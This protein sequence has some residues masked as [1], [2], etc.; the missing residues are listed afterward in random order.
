METTVPQDR[1][2]A[3]RRALRLLAAVCLIG[4]APAPLHAAD[5]GPTAAVLPVA[6]RVAHP[7]P[8]ELGRMMAAALAV[9]LSGNGMQQ[10]T[11]LDDV[12]AGL[13][14]EEQRAR[15]GC[16]GPQCV[17]ELGGALGVDLVVVGEVL[18]VGTDVMWTA[19]VVEVSSSAVKARGTV[20]ANA[21]D[22]LPAAADEMALQLGAEA[23]GPAAERLGLTDGAE[24]FAAYRAAN[25]SSTTAE[26]LTAFILE[27]NTESTGLAVFEGVL[28][29][30]SNALLGGACS[31]TI[32]GVMAF[33]QGQ[34]APA[35]VAGALVLSALVVGSALGVA[36]VVAA[37]VD[38]LT[39]RRVTVESRG[40]CR[41]DAA[42][43][44]ADNGANV[45]QAAVVIALASA[46]LAVGALVS[47]GALVT[48]SSLM[49]GDF[50][51]AGQEAVRRPALWLV[52][53]ALVCS[54]PVFCTSLSAN[55]LTALLLTLW[56]DKPRVTQVSNHPE[57]ALDAD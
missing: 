26:A 47:T 32:L 44:D 17:Q 13:S 18:P 23:P 27:R 56:P 24:A 21:A 3:V 5:N 39:L 28:L 55:A 12:V 35:A 34:F 19:S 52:G 50:T 46:P 43:E 20:R 36:A 16:D 10:L 37:V 15:I 54:L 30:I 25:T 29:L 22:S 33:S 49:G 48:L 6:V 14:Y 11:T 57:V 8:D 45:R 40:C 51:T 4:F 2:P 41:D 31:V 38:A 7:A 53:T 1:I 42:L 9:S